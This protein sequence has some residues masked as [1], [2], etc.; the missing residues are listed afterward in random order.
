MRPGCAADSRVGHSGRRVMR[1]E[2]WQQFLA[3]VQSIAE[4][5]RA[6]DITPRRITSGHPSTP[7]FNDPAYP[8]EGQPVL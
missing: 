2:L 6:K 8:I 1:P 3:I 5:A 4:H 7:G